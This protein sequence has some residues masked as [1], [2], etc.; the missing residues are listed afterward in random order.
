MIINIMEKKEYNTHIAPILASYMNK[1]ANTCNVPQITAPIYSCLSHPDVLNYLNESM[2]M[3]LDIYSGVYNSKDKIENFLDL[4]VKLIDA[5][6]NVKEI[7]DAYSMTL[8][9]IY[10]ILLSY[11]TMLMLLTACNN[12]RSWTPPEDALEAN[13]E[14]LYYMLSEMKKWP[15]AV[16]QALDIDAI[17]SN[18]ALCLFSPKNLMPSFNANMSQERLAEIIGEQLQASINKNTIVWR[19]SNNM[20]YNIE[21]LNFYN[22][23]L[24]GCERNPVTAKALYLLGVHRRR[25]ERQYMR[26]NPPKYNNNSLYYMSTFE[27]ENQWRELVRQHEVDNPRALARTSVSYLHRQHAHNMA[28]ELVAEVER[29]RLRILL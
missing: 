25:A 26:A 6:N 11:V 17:C 24:S 28:S 18:A 4:K 2:K 5:V 7:E 8:R 3:A 1:Y 14:G 19:P 13:L 21:V 16:K 22:N 10:C 9:T 15:L 23:S 12:D 27:L 29:R 20:R